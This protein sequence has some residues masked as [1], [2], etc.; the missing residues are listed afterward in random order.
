VRDAWGRCGRGAARLTLAVVLAAVTGGDVR[1]ETETVARAPDLTEL[2]LEE[3]LATK[4]TSV[5][6]KRE[7]RSHAADAIYVITHE[8]IVRSGVR[9]LADAL[10]LA[11]GVQVARVDSNGWAIG[12]RGFASRLARSVLVLV[13][14]RTVYN[15]LFA[16]TYWEVQDYPLEDVDRIEIIRGPGGT[17]WGANAFNGVIN[18]ITKSARET[19]GG[20]LEAG[21][22]TEERAF[23]TVRYGGRLAEGAWY[24]GYAS[25]F[26]RDAL[27]NPSGREY[28]AWRMGRSGFRTDWDVG[29]RDSVTVQGDV[30][31][32]S[33]GDRV[34]VTV[35]RPPFRRVLREDGDVSGA[36]LLGRWTRVLG[37]GSDLSLQVYYDNFDRDDPNFSELRNTVDLDFQHRFPLLWRQE[38]VW[39]LG[40]RASADRTR[41]LPGNA[42]FRPANRTVQ[43]FSGFLQDE[44]T[45]VEDLLRVTVGTK[46][47]HNDLSGIEVQPSARV[48][49]T[50]H[51]LHTFWAAVARAVRT[52]SRIEHDF[53]ATGFAASD[54]PTFVRA[55]GNR[56]FE[57]EK[58]L[59]YQLGYRT[60]PLPR[61]F[62]DVVAF[63]NDF[64]DLLSVEPGSVFTETRPGVPH[65]VLPFT[66][67]NG[68]HGES[69]GVEV[70]ADTAL[71]DWWR[72]NAAY[73]YVDVRL[74]ADPDSL[75]TT[76]AA[77][78]GNSPHSMVTLRS[79]MN[80]PGRF[81]LDLVGRYVD[82]L[83]ALRIGSYVELDVRVARR[84]GRSVELA[85]VGQNLLHDHHREFAGGTEV[86]RGA[87]GMIRWW[88]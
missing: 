71:T 81:Q 74:R 31:A 88:W 51:V 33:L 64:D 82:N 32:G 30:F 46:V 60:R 42:G 3:L 67:A 22:G 9:T 41:G 18:V 20:Y 11:P 80:L 10:R 68:L 84:F 58:V 50:P 37:R 77:A 66:F 40:Y 24:R 83:P 8:E 73:S 5:S 35:Y 2:S 23:G 59:D 21:A 48:L 55:V 34:P 75:D 1:A 63:Y 17:L 65:F 13:D 14:G 56:D 52:P 36:N 49:W 69:H 62:V 57:S 70:A 47:E 28:D 16:G 53:F 25:G 7:P 85:V 6:R 38:V 19:Q 61:L 4:V 44:V 78:A 27:F 43:L 45:L 29:T 39:G 79:L 86:E 72:L 54:P 76:Q 87:Y 15:P 26:D 12:V